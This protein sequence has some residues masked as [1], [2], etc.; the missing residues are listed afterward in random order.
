MTYLPDCDYF[1]YFEKLPWSI[2]GMVSMDEDGIFSIF[3]NNR[4]PMS[5][6]IKTFRHELDHILNDDFYNGLPIEQVEGL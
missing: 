5:V 6:L 3:L 1:V 2:R 4:Y